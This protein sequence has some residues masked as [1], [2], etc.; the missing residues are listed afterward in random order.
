MVSLEEKSSYQVRIN[1]SQKL[2][3]FSNLLL[4]KSISQTEIADINESDEIYFEIVKAI[5]TN[6]KSL[7]ETYFNKK[8]KSNPNKESPSPFVNDDF[9]IFCLIVGI[10]KFA[11]DKSW[12]KNIVSL[13][14]RNA[15]TITLENIIN[16]NFYSTSNLPEII[17]MFFKLQTP[18]LITNDFLTIAFKSISDNQT[19][20]ESKSDFHIICSIRA[21]DL[22][23]ELKEST[24]GS[25]VNLLKEFNTK[26]IARL[27]VITWFVQTII[28]ILLLYG[29]IK[30][31]TL[32]PEIKNL[33]DKIGSVMK[34]LSL[35]GISQLG[36][37]F[38]FIKKKL[39]EAML[40][41]FGYPRDLL[42][43]SD[44]NVD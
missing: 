40:K 21:Y 22:I 42:K 33:F 13:R 39:F 19:L 37:F 44:T 17:L 18:T 28:L 43:K 7:F 14:G 25:E 10:I 32:K 20:F 27:K 23:I 12:I 8:N 31:I 5:Q 4:G 34:V 41:L 29:V 11:C 30:I 16:E 3:A 6:D 35:I 15:F 24:E 38:P 9:L 36:N 2:T 1:E 26:F